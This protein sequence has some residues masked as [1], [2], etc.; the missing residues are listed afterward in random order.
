MNTLENTITTMGLL[1]QEAYNVEKFQIGAEIT[2]SNKK[3]KV[4]DYANTASDF[5]ALLLQDASGKFVMAFR[6]TTSMLD[7][8]NNAGIGFKNINEQYNDSLKVA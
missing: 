8:L 3:Y 4:I 7:W 6:G 2:A 1:S 5:Q